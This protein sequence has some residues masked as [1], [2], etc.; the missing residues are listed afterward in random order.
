MHRINCGNDRKFS[1]ARRKKKRLIKKI[2]KNEE[3]SLIID[4]KNNDI[5]NMTK[6]IVGNN[7]WNLDMVSKNNTIPIKYSINGCIKDI[8]YLYNTNF[9]FK[10]LSDKQ[11]NTIVKLMNE[12]SNI[13]PYTFEYTDEYLDS[14]IDFNFP[15]IDYFQNLFGND[16]NLV[17]GFANGPLEYFKN[18]I[19]LGVA[20]YTDDEGSAGSIFINYEVSDRLFNPGSDGYYTLIHELGHALGIWHPHDDGGNSKI[21]NGVERSDD[22]GTK[23]SNH[24]INTVMSYN[25]LG[26]YS[27][28]Y[29]AVDVAAL[30]FMYG[31]ST[32]NSKKVY[33]LKSN[34][35]TTFKCI[36]DETKPNIINAQNASEGVMINLNTANL[37]EN[38][39]NPGGQISS[40]KSTKIFKGGFT[41]AKNTVINKIFGSL[42]NDTYVFNNSYTDLAIDGNLG[43]NT[44]KINMNFEDFDRIFIKKNG[45][46]NI[47]NKEKKI[48]LRNVQQ[49]N[50]KDKKLNIKENI[51]KAI[52]DG[53][54]INLKK[55]Y[56]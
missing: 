36:Y 9:K 7:K 53:K 26:S 31:K 8:N 41:L 33:K 42:Y 43:E 25:I 50:F 55:I 20:K 10:E 46:V 6:V 23:K 1:N 15:R 37:N 30:H 4:C 28:T 32:Q 2:K 29:M 47:L 56:K 39:N 17:L 48:R 35:T 12:L 3:N 14:L 52:S 40:C 19:E 13:I 38:K 21:M 44:F 18:T 16:Y 22:L 24:S 34:E 45:I 49:L 54:N 51:E 11:K 5:T 27:S